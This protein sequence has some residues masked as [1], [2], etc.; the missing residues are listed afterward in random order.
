MAC[1]HQ[2]IYKKSYQ[3][4]EKFKYDTVPVA[5]KG[6]WELMMMEMKYQFLNQNM[7]LLLPLKF[8]QKKYSA[9]IE[10]PLTIDKITL[11]EALEIVPKVVAEL[12]GDYIILKKGKNGYFISYKK[13]YTVSI[14]NSD[15][16]KKD[17]IN[18]IKEKMGSIIE[19]K[20]DGMNITI[21]EGPFGPYFVATPKGK[22]KGV[23]Y[24]IPA[25]IEDFK[26]ISDEKIKEIMAQPK[27]KFTK[28][29]FNK[30]K[31]FYSKK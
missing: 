18:L 27:K 7:V 16:S 23:N 4:S 28:K 25:N 21:K 24:K 12:D 13:K 31:K 15:I 2:E 29:R 22:K 17:A 9:N 10:P 14:P 1:L 5:A 6:Y 8:L 3:P 19:R 26:N 30:T 20:V 11:E